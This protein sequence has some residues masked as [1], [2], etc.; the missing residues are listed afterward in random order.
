MTTK[1][2]EVVR[3]MCLRDRVDRGTKKRKYIH[4]IR[5]HRRISELPFRYMSTQL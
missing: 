1:V 2:V 5:L 3:C 4:W